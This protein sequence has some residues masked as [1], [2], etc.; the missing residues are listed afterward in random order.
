M[1]HNNYTMCVCGLSDMYTLSP[2]ASDVR[3]RQTTHAHGIKTHNSESRGQEEA[4]RT[5]QTSELFTGS[6]TVEIC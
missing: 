6:T 2:Q 5:R 4:G 1:V 3:I